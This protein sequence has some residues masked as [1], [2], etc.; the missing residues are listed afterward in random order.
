[1]ERSFVLFFV[2]RNERE[3]Y[4]GAVLEYQG[5]RYMNGIHGPCNGTLGDFLRHSENI[6]GDTGSLTPQPYAL[7]HA[8]AHA[9]ATGGS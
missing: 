1:M 5:G 6:I 8:A 4:A 3:L 2:R 7:P 9:R